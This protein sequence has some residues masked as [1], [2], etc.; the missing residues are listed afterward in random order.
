MNASTKPDAEAPKLCELIDRMNFFSVWVER[1]AKHSKSTDMN[2][3]LSAPT[4]SMNNLLTLNYW[5]Q[6]KQ[7]VENAHTYAH[8]HTSQQINRISFDDE[9]WNVMIHDS[10]D[11][12]LKIPKVVHSKRTE[13]GFNPKTKSDI[14]LIAKQMCWNVNKTPSP[15]TA[16]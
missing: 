12:S 10:F 4:L 15:Q 3:L 2:Q 1:D 11:R 13:H 16:I 9:L 6:L 7:T 8:A 5:K 14:L